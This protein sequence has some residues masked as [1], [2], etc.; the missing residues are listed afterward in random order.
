MAELNPRHILTWKEAEEVRS[1]YAGGGFTQRELA[2]QYGTKEGAIG[3]VLRNE[4][5]V[6]AVK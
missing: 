5:W 6:R 1:K 4:T 3:R 2:E